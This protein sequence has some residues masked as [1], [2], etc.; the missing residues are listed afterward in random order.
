MIRLLDQR[1]RINIGNAAMESY[2]ARLGADCPFFISAEPSYAEGIGEI[3]SPVNITDHNLK[4]HTLVVVKPDVAVSTK[5]A[6][7][8][9]KP[10]QPELCCRDIVDS[11]FNNECSA[12]GKRLF[13]LFFADL[14][15]ENSEKRASASAHL[16]IRGAE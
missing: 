8:H 15:I 1:F 7:S 4:G 14:R 13:C 10:R 9:I 3:L 2:A 6:F 12:I 5:E 11:Q 16:R